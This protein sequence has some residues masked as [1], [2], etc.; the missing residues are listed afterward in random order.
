MPCNMVVTL[1]GLE[2]FRRFG[3]H[4]KYVCIMTNYAK[5]DKA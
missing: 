1:G 4:T 3:S 2:N 5:D